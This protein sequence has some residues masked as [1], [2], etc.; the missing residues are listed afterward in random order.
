MDRGKKNPFR[1]RK[2]SSQPPLRRKADGCLRVDG[3]LRAERVG[4]RERRTV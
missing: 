2:G 4:L 3:H 1:E